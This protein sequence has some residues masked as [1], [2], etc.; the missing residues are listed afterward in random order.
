M[1]RVHTLKI[2]QL[3]WYGIHQIFNLF[4]LQ[5][6]LRDMSTGTLLIRPSLAEERPGIRGHLSLRH[7]ALSFQ[8]FSDGLSAGDQERGFNRI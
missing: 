4:I 5:I 1:A 8:T 7:D 6:S 3:I 2:E